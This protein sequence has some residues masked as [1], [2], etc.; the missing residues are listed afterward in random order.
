[1]VLIHTT[2]RFTQVPRFSLFRFLC[3]VALA[4]APFLWAQ[5]AYA[6]DIT[7]AWDPNA[8]EDL[9]G[10]RVFY[11]QEGQSYDY[12][13]PAWEGSNTT[14]TIS[15]L[16]DNTAYY[17]VARALDTSGNESSNSNEVAY[18]PSGNDQPTAD[19]GPNQTAD[20]DS[21][22]TLDGSNSSDPDGTISSYQWTQTAGTA[23]TLSSAS[24][25]QPTFA[26]PSVGAGGVALTFELTVTDNG[27]LSDT[28]TVIVNVSNVNQA[29]TADAGP[30]Q[31]VDEGATVTLNASNS[32]D[33]D[34][35]ISSYQWTQTAGTAV[36]LSSTS[37][38]QPTFAAPTVSAGGEALVFELEV[39]DDRGL[40]DTDSVIINVSNVNQA[41]VA[42]A[43]SD[44]TVNEGATVYLDGSGSLDPDGAIVSYRWTQ[45]SGTSMTLSDPTSPTPT[46][47]APSI[48]TGGEAL[49]FELT[50]SDDGDLSDTDAVI[51]N[52]SPVHANDAP[53]ADAG[54]DQTVDGADEVALDGS[55]S[56]DPDG[57]IVSYRWTQTL[58]TAVTLSDASAA[59]PTFTAPDVGTDGETL[60]FEVTVTDDGGLQSADAC[61]VY[62]SSVES[63]PAVIGLSINSQDSLDE[64]TTSSYTA[65]AIFSDGSSQD[66]TEAATWDE[67]SSFASIDASG[68]LWA[69][70]V[71][72]D[73]SVTI[74]A[75]YTHG[76]I[77]ETAQKV[78]TILDVVLLNLA[79]NQ[80]VIT[81]PYYGQVGCELLSH[82]LTEPFS[83]PDADTHLKSQWQISKELDFATFALDLTTLNHLT[84][85]PVP[86]MV[87]DPD[88]TIYVR[89]RFYDANGAASFWSDVVEFTTEADEDD[90]DGNG[91]P[92]VQEVGF[93]VDLN[94]DSIAD[95]D[96]PELIKCVESS[97]AS[98]VICV[99]KASSSILSIE[100]VGTIDVTVVS[101]KKRR[102]R[103]FLYGLFSYRIGVNQPG[104]TATVR[105]YFSQNIGGARYFYKYDTLRG[106]Q[107]YS[108]FTTF[109]KRENFITLHV[110]DGGPGDSDGVANGVIT[111][112]GALVEEASVEEETTQEDT[113]QESSDT[114]DAFTADDEAVAA[115]TG[116]CFI[117]TGALHPGS[118]TKPRGIVI[119]S[120]SVVQ[121][122][123][124]FVMGTALGLIARKH[125]R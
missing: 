95:N 61:S 32:S 98:V 108:S 65:T 45:T 39:T 81:S 54:I 41:P 73:Q 49:G 36:T 94:Q 23:V 63:L 43:G 14:C 10:Y 99:A 83:D 84:D 44:Q 26:A 69:F 19:A 20:E 77:T 97:D 82:I 34:G 109:N 80:P 21:T 52:I 123:V 38:A 30:N 13:L 24:A 51:I 33:P 42:Q 125:W 96:Q 3:L 11:H 60:V 118:Y 57:S 91:I 58:G 55:G 12:N 121:L 101:E 67:D 22:V 18:E 6:I 31:T 106:W 59:Q 86:R 66:V 7:L 70:E 37:A 25:A 46:F 122:M 120:A 93:D 76:G 78:V 71:E 74:T 110:E 48:D 56:F 85:L 16:D 112:P 53:T 15:N 124:V 104:A 5:N 4:F 35:T 2:R 8:E 47:T 62:V 117:T 90:L 113:S 1:M 79:P 75:S 27:G 115:A 29:P 28:D 17:F 103:K 9:D 72:S 102:P 64:N 89:V 116:G 107:D 68:V 40:K 100:A 114:S 50:V 88:T 111:D 119:F 105:V 87:L 92:D